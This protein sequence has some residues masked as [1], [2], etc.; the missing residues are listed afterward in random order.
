MTPEALTTVEQE[1]RR[2]SARGELLAGSERALDALDGEHDGACRPLLSR[3]AAD[4]ERLAATD[5][6]L[7]EPAQLLREA[8]LQAHEAVA[9]LDVDRPAPTVGGHTADLLDR[10]ARS[11]KANTWHEGASPRA[12]RRYG[13][14]LA[15][16]TALDRPSPTLNASEHKASL[17]FHPRGGTKDDRR[18]STRLIAAVAAESQSAPVRM[19]VAQLAALQSFPAGFAFHGTLSSQHKQVG[20]AV[21]PPLAAAIGRS[22]ATALYGGAP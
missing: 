19:T 22:I 3:L 21:P 11:V 6:A 16:A 17:N 2:L 12:S 20:N 14:R 13:A 15:A 5:A 4:P 18:A 7:A 9:A 1:H 10:P 8:A